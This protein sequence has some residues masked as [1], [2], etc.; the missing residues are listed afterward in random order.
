MPNPAAEG[1][2][3]AKHPNVASGYPS[4]YFI[5][6]EGTGIGS[7]A[8]NTLDFYANYTKAWSLTSSGPTIPSGKTLAVTSADGLTVGGNIVPDYIYVVSADA[9]AT[10]M[11][12]KNIFTCPRAMQLVGASFSHG[13]ASSG[14]CNVQVEKCTGTTAPGSGTGLLTNNTNTGFDANATANTVQ[15]GTLTGTTASL[16]FAAGDRVSVKWG[17]STGCVGSVVTLI[18][19]PI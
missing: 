9:I 13:T 11:V 12:S 2:G 5:N 19:K 6:D 18:F 8:T 10:A 4:L 17:T 14:A 16:Q 1:L 7:S 3:I 15:A